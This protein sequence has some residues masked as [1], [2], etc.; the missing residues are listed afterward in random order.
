MKRYTL[1]MQLIDAYDSIWVSC[2]NEV[3][4][5][6][7]GHNADELADN[8]ELTKKLFDNKNMEPYN[9]RIKI[10]RASC[11]ERV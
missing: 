4:E 5:T 2:F 6:L 11:R 3:G 1:N 7:L 8:P 10:G 9:F